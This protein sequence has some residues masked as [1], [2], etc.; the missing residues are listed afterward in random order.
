LLYKGIGVDGVKTGHT[1][2]A[3]YCLTASVKR[4]NRRLIAVITGLGSMGDRSDESERIIEWA[5]NSFQNYA[6]LQQGQ[7]L[8]EAGVWLGEAEKVPLLAGKDVTVSLARSARPGMKVVLDY[9]SPVQAPV[10]RGQELGTVTVT[11]PGIA[12]IS[13]PVVAG[14]DVPELG[15]FGRMAA[16]LSYLLG[17]KH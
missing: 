9:A 15:R 17:H 10:V 14:A 1:G 16:A 12:P 13:V 4:G 11:A 5:V 8:G 6:L 3:G 2:E 7:Q